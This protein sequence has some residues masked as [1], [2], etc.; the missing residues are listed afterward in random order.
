MG[1]LFPSYAPHKKR[2]TVASPVCRI[3]SLRPKGRSGGNPRPRPQ[4][5]P[6]SIPKGGVFKK[7]LQ[8]QDWC[9]V[10]STSLRIIPSPGIYKH[11]PPHPPPPP[12][13]LMKQRNKLGRGW[14]KGPVVRPHCKPPDKPRKPGLALCTTQP[15]AGK[16]EAGGPGV[17]ASLAPL[18]VC[19][20]I[21]AFYPSF[22]PMRLPPPMGAGN[23]VKTE[24]RPRPPH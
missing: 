21:N 23:E 9:R 16:S 18:P 14:W 24:C 5:H 17:P 4:P 12:P 11:P 10:T 8:A 3:D 6:W 7:L 2:P 1:A 15:S 20:C 19:L 22:P 13:R